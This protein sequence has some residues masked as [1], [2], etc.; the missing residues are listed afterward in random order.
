MLAPVGVDAA[1]RE[2]LPLYVPADGPAK[3]V[4]TTAPRTVGPTTRGASA[5]LTAVVQTAYPAAVSP[6][7]ARL[8]PLAGVN[9]TAALDGWWT[10]AG[11]SGRATLGRRFSAWEPWVDGHGWCVQGVLRQGAGRRHVPVEVHLWGHGALFTRVTMTPRTKVV[12][13]RH[14]FRVGHEAL[15][16]LARALS[17]ALRR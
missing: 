15:D 10:R 9:L 17:E 2:E 5:A 6:C 12:A 11:R 8:I 3:G 4:R 7:F 14:Y 16:D 1:C 13:T